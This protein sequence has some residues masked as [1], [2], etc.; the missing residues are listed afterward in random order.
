M[1]KDQWKNDPELLKAFEDG[2][3]EAGWPGANKKVGDLYVKRSETSFVASGRIASF[4]AQA[5]DIDKAIFW[6]EKS[7]KEHSPNLP[8]AFGSRTYEQLKDNPR[9]KELAR[10]MNLS[11][12]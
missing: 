12:K 7:Y 1:Q 4:Y 9:F 6:L 3:A 2:Y 11:V 10:K 5:G 8:Y